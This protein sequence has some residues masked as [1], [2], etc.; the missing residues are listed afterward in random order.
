MLECLDVFT[1]LWKERRGEEKDAL[2]FVTALANSDATSDI[3]PAVDPTT[4]LGTLMLLIVGGNDT[5]RNT[6]SGGVVALNEFPEQYE[7]LRNDPGLI[8]SFVDEVIR[9]Q[10]PLA[11]MRRTATRDT[12]LGGQNI[13]KGD[14]IVMVTDGD[15]SCGGDM[16]AAIDRIHDSAVT[17]RLDVV[18]FALADDDLKARMAGWAEA[19]GGAYFDATSG[20]ELAAAMADAISTSVAT[21]D[22]TGFEVLGEDG[23]VVRT[24]TVGGGPVALDPGTYRVEVAL[25][26][27]AIYDAVTVGRGGI[28]ELT[29]D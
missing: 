15:E 18:G 8:P 2:D 10:T 24:G 22:G 25:S 28:V 3:D 6:I 19:G 16:H 13:K 7:K 21:A 17:F 14:S 27:P 12:V 1:R 20:D 4:Y 29:L 11:H 23:T 26:T 9:W 5:T